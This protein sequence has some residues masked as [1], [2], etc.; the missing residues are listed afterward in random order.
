MRLAMERHVLSYGLKLIE[1][2]MDWF[3][4]DIDKELRSPNPPCGEMIVA[5]YLM[6]DYSVVLLLGDRLFVDQTCLVF[7]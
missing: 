5:L 2:P 1:N 6:M 3:T 7:Q 4:R